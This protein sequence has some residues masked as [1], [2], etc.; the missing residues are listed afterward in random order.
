MGAKSREE[1]KSIWVTG[2][3]VTETG[4]DDVWD[5][6]H[7]KT[8]DEYPDI[9]A[10]N[11]GDGAGLVYASDH[12]QTFIDNSLVSKKYVDTNVQG[13]YGLL[14]GFYFTSGIATETVIGDDDTNTWT[15][16]ILDIHTDGTFDNR[17]VIM[18]DATSVGH[19]G[20]GL[21]NSP[22]IFT[23]EGLSTTAFASFR[24]SLSFEPDIDE[25]QLESRILFT[26]HTGATPNTDFSIEEVTLGMNSGAD[27][28]YTAE[29]ALSFFIGDTIDT[30]GVND[31]G[32]FK[33]QIKSDVP[34]ILHTRAL[35]LYIHK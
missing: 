29:P 8:D 9:G 13:Y 16:I 28:E 19:T 17:P 24:S 22:I 10:T 32:T 3:T 6:F 11:S 35:T 18:Q 25:G 12:T 14:S 2:A 7:N 5:S 15:D 20:T 30:N 21:V 23:L 34:G 33:F 26:R 31:S 27:I 1:L 4:F